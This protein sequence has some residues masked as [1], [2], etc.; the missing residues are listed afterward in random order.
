[1]RNKFER[2]FKL[3]KKHQIFIWP[4]YIFKRKKINLYKFIYPKL[5]Y[6]FFNRPIASLRLDRLPFKNKIKKPNKYFKHL[7]HNL[8]EIV[9]NY[10]SNIR[11]VRFKKYFFEVKRRSRFINFPFTGFNFLIT[12]ETRLDSLLLK[13]CLADTM[14]N[15]KDL[16]KRGFFLVNN[17][18]SFNC[19]LELKPWSDVLSIN[20]KYKNLFYNRLLLKFIFLKT[21]SS[22]IFKLMKK[23]R[24]QFKYISK[25][26]YNNSNYIMSN[27]TFMHFWMF[28]FPCKKDLKYPFKINSDFF[29][30]IFHKNN[31]Y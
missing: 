9:N 29:N 8:V 23:K 30:G 13:L 21:S 1:M 16:L 5:L 19:N 27:Y 4:H 2:K 3:I 7:Q 10:Y 20:F 18:I 22:R 28:K 24:F 11:P 17:R 31:H 15:A 25:I 6:Y 26:L 14:F 12:L